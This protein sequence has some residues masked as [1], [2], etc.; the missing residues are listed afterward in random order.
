MLPRSLYG[1]L[2]PHQKEGVKWLNSLYDERKGGVLGDDMG[3]G[4]TLMSIT[5]LWTLLNQGIDPKNPSKS[6]VSRAI[7]ACPTSL[8]GNWDNE[9]KKWISGDRCVTFP[10]RSEAKKS[11]SEI[12]LFLNDNLSSGK[13]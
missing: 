9:I 8:V 1:N 2:F 11:I 4:K 6:A 13:E 10:V 7:V 12:A 5:L 3:L